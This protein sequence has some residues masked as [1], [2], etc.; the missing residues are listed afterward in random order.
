[1]NAI[2]G[3][4]AALQPALRAAAGPRLRCWRSTYMP[5]LNSD[6][7][8]GNNIRVW[9]AD[10][11]PQRAVGNGLTGLGARWVCAQE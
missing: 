6:P 8:V 11:A 9:N 7:T 10:P 2:T 4:V 1:V 3:A 5:L